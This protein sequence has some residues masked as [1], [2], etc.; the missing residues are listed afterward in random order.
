[1][2]FKKSYLVNE[3]DLPSSAMVDKITGTS[4]W[5]VY[6]EIVFE[7]QGKFYQTEYSVGTTEMQD[8]SPW[9]YDD[10]VDCV[11]VELKPVQVMKWVPKSN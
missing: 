11:E 1:M 8:E 5:S 7:H 2:K 6:H 4:R 9:K 10:E 3:L